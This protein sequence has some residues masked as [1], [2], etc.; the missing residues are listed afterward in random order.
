MS[1][2]ELRIGKAQEIHLS[3]NLTFEQKIEHLKNKGFKI[4]DFDE[5]GSYIDCKNLV[6][7]KNRFFEILEDEDFIY[8]DVASATIDDNG[9]I[10]Y[11]LKYYNGGAGFEDMFE[12]A[13]LNMEKR[14][15]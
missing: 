9:V 1:D 11:T 14:D 4:L 6:A 5:N 3:E 10:S 8:D 15:K 13:I 2:T 7:C 12:Q